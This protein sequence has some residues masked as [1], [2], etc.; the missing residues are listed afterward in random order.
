MQRCINLIRCYSIDVEDA[1]LDYKK[2]KGKTKRCINLV[3]VLIN[4]RGSSTAGQ[5]L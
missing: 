3:S 2:E 4:R 5:L 1:E